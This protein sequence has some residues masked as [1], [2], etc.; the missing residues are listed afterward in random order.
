MGWMQIQ[1]QAR[2]ADGEANGDLANLMQT[3]AG[4]DDGVKKNAVTYNKG[5]AVMVT[6][7]DLKTMLGK[8]VN[9]GDD[10]KVYMQPQIKGLDVLPFDPSQLTKYF[11]VRDPLHLESKWSLLTLPLCSQRKG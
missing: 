6:E 4:D 10:G 5:D 3:L 7:G 9:V 2:Q 11:K 8:V 1:Q